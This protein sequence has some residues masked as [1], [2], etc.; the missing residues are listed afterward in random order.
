MNNLMK[1]IKAPAIIA[2]LLVP[3]I[4]F[5][6][7]S[8]A[9]G[10]LGAATN[11]FFFLLG[12]FV[13]IVEFIVFSIFAIVLIIFEILVQ[14]T[15]VNFSSFANSSGIQIGWSVTRDLANIII[16][17]LLLYLGVTSIFDI[18][19][20]NLKSSFVK[21]VFVALLI[22]FSAF[23]TRVLIDVSNVVTISIYN[24]I[25][26]NAG[27][28]YVVLGALNLSTF[29]N[30]KS[31]FTPTDGT[32]NET[33]IQLLVLSVGSIVVYILAIWAISRM[34]WFLI[35]RFLA[36]IMII[37]FSP[38]GF[39]GAVFGKD[40][41]FVKDISNIWLGHLKSYAVG[42]PIL[43]LLIYLSILVA[44]GISTLPIGLQSSGDTNFEVILKGLIG[45]APAA[46]MLLLSVKITERILSSVQWADGAGKT[47][48]G[49]TRKFSRLTLSK[50][51]DLSIPL[52]NS[53]PGPI[54]RTQKVF[55][56]EGNLNVVTDRRKLFEFDEE[57]TKKGTLGAF[58]F[59]SKN[60][61]TPEKIAAQAPLIAFKGADLAVQGAKSTVKRV[62]EE[63]DNE[64]AE[65]KA[66][67]IA[68][69]KKDKVEN[70][71]TWATKSIKFLKGIEE[72]TVIN[73]NGEKE[74]VY[75]EQQ[76]N[77]AAEGRV[78]LQSK[79]GR[80]KSAK[81]AQEKKEAVSRL[82]VGNE[83]INQ[84]INEVTIS[85]IDSE[86]EENRKEQNKLI[87]IQEGETQGKEEGSAGTGGGTAGEVEQ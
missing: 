83:G 52:I 67:R 69:K 51:L 10:A 26:A 77:Q 63:L 60:I 46:G 12:L 76:R 47:L 33:V 17:I 74:F 19:A 16:V 4:F 75:T 28:S 42:L 79:L 14:E 35:T 20:H 34:V 1:R 43:F 49:L 86:L 15:V 56:K 31:T 36:L 71:K 32:T 3:F 11:I 78:N 6:S 59:V 84:V 13:S 8:F 61:L 9:F 30:D 5:F 72:K 54:K 62:K 21:L 81:N 45:V 82:F 66:A 64:T 48:F 29:L 87:N 25:A 7:Y 39:A 80:L 85:N 53:I 57:K 41:K 18:D 68:K 38:I 50:G 24:A 2:L 44:N 55:D 37:L 70:V 40:G 22:N 73:E 27:I 58:D 23:L 65:E